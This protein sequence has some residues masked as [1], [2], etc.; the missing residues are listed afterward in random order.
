MTYL[1][2]TKNNDSI[3][4]NDK[5]I[6]KTM[7]NF[8]INTTK[9]VNLKPYKES[10]LADINEITSNFDNYVSIKKIK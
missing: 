5:D 3:L 8:F 7:N 6:A 9:N 2:K 1:R 4:T 10:S